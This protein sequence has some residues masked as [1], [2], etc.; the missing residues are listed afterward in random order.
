MTSVVDEF[1]D[2][3]KDSVLVS[4]SFDSTELCSACQR[5]EAGR[6]CVQAERDL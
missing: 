5:G 4:D 2:L 3:W 1:H 6:G